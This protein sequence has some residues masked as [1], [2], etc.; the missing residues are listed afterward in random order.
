[1]DNE[2]KF[3]DD[4]GY[5]PFK[6]TFLDRSD[7]EFTYKSGM[8]YVSKELFDFKLRLSKGFYKPAF[9]VALKDLKHLE[10]IENQ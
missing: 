5:R 8:Y 4:N 9:F 6:I 2:K 3:M 1:M 10:E 7:G